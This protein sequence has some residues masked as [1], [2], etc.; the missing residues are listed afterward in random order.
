VPAVDPHILST[1]VHQHSCS[2][3]VRTGDDVVDERGNRRV[4]GE[5]P[6][7]GR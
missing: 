5:P 1:D 6:R 3:V 2:I 7:H 4:T